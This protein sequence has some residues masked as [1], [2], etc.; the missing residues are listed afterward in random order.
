MAADYCSCMQR[1]RHP[2]SPSLLPVF[3]AEAGASSANS[4]S[5]EGESNPTLVGKDTADP[6]QQSKRET[7]Q[8]YTEGIV[9]TP[10]QL[11]EP[12]HTP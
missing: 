7:M 4:W 6:M 12:P 2:L 1:Q 8:A 10:T 3:P 9:S 5:C 11:L